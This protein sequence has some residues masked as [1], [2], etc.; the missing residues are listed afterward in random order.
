M[1]LLMSIVLLG[2]TLNNTNKIIS[3]RFQTTDATLIKQVAGS[4]GEDVSDFIRLSVRR[5][6]AR[7]S[8]L[9]V[10]EKKALEVKEE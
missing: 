1:Y 8:Y 5:E 2:D 4:R 6:L 3:V 10:D 9:S 7:L